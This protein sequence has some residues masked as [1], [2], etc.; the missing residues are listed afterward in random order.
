MSSAGV[1]KINPNL[2]EY[3]LDHRLPLLLYVGDVTVES[4]FAGSALLYRL[5]QNYP[6]KRLRVIEGS[7]SVSHPCK[8]LPGVEYWKLRVGTERLLRTR[9]HPLYSSLLHLTATLRLGQL[10]R[11]EKQF[12]PEAIL[13]V[14]QGYT[15]V[16]AACIAKKLNLPL[17]LI[18][19][20]DWVSV[21]ENV[22]P[23]RI[24]KRVKQQFKEIYQLAESRLCVSPYLVEDFGKKYGVTGTVLYPSRAA[25]V[26]E[27]SHPPISNGSRKKIVAA[28]AGTINTP[29]YASSLATL[30][31][32]LENLGGE[33]IVYSNLSDIDIKN[34]GLDKSNVIN[35]PILPFKELLHSLRKEVDVLFVPMSFRM[36]DAQNMKV[37]FPS[38]LADYTVVGLPLLIWGPP[39]C[40]AVRWARENPGVAEVVT[41]FDKEELTKA[42]KHLS[43]DLDYRYKLAEVALQKGREFFSH[44][45]AI[46]KFYKSIT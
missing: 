25:D 40:S 24:H 33:L 22:L 44:S 42:I 20:D 14:A 37:S 45:T 28:F 1:R 38:K 32:V 4:T 36:E 9:F 8:R 5:L 27:Y 30:T 21:Q 11:I 2:T 18:I 12:R 19:H 29:G 31:S 17:H 23:A 7:L 13:T 34:C 10:D 39:Y 16:T 43:Q 41:K 15:W 26:P 46:N 6:V 35:R 3:V